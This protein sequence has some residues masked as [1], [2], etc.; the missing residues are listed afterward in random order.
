METIYII[1][2]LLNQGQALSYVKLHIYFRHF[3]YL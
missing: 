1:L 3:S 2:I